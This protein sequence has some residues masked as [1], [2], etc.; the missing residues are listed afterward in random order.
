MSTAEEKET[1]SKMADRPRRARRAQPPPTPLPL[2]F[3]YTDSPAFDTALAWHLD[4]PSGP[5]VAPPTPSPSST[6][7]ATVVPGP[8]YEQ[9]PWTPSPHRWSSSR[10]NNILAA[11]HWLGPDLPPPPAGDLLLFDELSPEL[12]RWDGDLPV[13]W[14]QDRLLHKLHK[15]KALSTTSLEDPESAGSV[16]SPVQTD[17]SE[18]LASL[19]DWTPRCVSPL[20]VDHKGGA[21][22]KADPSFPPDG[23][24]DDNH[25]PT[26]QEK[27][28]DAHACSWSGCRHPSFASRD[29]LAWHVKAE[30]LLVCPVLGCPEASFSSARML[31]GHTTVAHP[32][33]CKDKVKEWQLSPERTPLSVEGVT[34]E[35]PAVAAQGGSGRTPQTGA[36][37]RAVQGAACSV[38]AAAKR[39]Y[40]DQL[41]SVVEKRARKSVDTPRAADSPTDIVRARAAKIVDTASFALVLEH[42]VLPFLAEMLPAWSGPWHVVSVTRGRSAH[43]RRICIMTRV[44]MSRPRKV[45]VASHVGDLLPEKYRRSISFVFSVGEVSRVAYWAR[46]L[47]SHHP[48]DVCS[49]RNPHHFRR[50]RMGDSVGIKG[51]GSVND[52]TA[53]LGPCLDVSGGAYWLVNFHPFLEAYQSFAPVSVEHP[54]P[55]DRARCRSEDHRVLPE[56]G[57]F[58]IGHVKVTSGLNLKTTR[59]SHD[60]YWD[61]CDTDHPLVVTDWALVKAGASG[62]NANML[63]R[64]PAE[65]RPNVMEPLVRAMSG[66][67]APGAAVVSSGR[68]SGYRRGQVCEVPAYVS[69]EANGT[70]KATR[71]WFVEE[72]PPPWDDEEAWI[73][74][75]IGVEGDSGAAVVDAETNC[76]V[77]Q[78]W[79][80]NK[81]W[82]PGP[83]LTFFTPVA[84]ILDDIQEK[85]GLQ[86]RPQLPQHRDDA[87]RHA[88]YP[89]C[90]RC[91][92]LCFYLDSRR[93]SRASL[94]SMLMGAEDHDLTSVEAASELATPRSFHRGTGVE[95]VGASFN[96]VS[97]PIDV[98]LGPTTPLIPSLAGGPRS[99]YPQSLELDDALDAA[100]SLGTSSSKRALPGI[101]FTFPPLVAEHLSK[102]PRTGW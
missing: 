97:S 54:S 78:L 87:D 18:A 10:S 25:V 95:E 36:C 102:R 81:Y 93:S 23:P 74:G 7:E 66:G 52:S 29:A 13:E 56:Q 98:R 59:I 32:N 34:R 53:T 61:D 47:D 67:V 9:R 33:V 91:Y 72:P 71:E 88:G 101:D 16:L 69:G 26:G 24:G 84:D 11:T 45:V 65:A 6:S 60:P 39:K 46:G 70:G 96:G 31:L 42:A 64:L 75:G 79:G 14:H 73:R 37:S 21:A 99:P 43:A 86:T 35:Q 19:V 80:R 55:Q 30:H 76:L 8:S 17:R 100:P 48:D 94:Q 1:A 49:P 89:T 92:E 27:A 85:C 3:G 41:R 15:G 83:R 51:S 12:N 62:R 44:R 82:G 20:A 50:Q 5:V 4:A 57:N 40:Q 68:T 90:R 28:A 38:A 63:R 22:A 77:G 2:P 58:E